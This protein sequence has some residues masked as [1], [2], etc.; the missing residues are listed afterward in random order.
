M[1]STELRRYLEAGD[2]S[3][4]RHLWQHEFPHLPQPQDDEE[5]LVVLHMARTLSDSMTLKLKAYSHRWLLDHGFPSQLPDE[6]KPLA[7]RIYPKVV[8]AVGLSVNTESELLKPVM[9]EVQKAMEGAVLEA[10]G[11]GKEGDIPHIRK[12]MK[13]ARERAVKALTIK[14]K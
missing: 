2:V 8:T 5:A 13:E 12:R 4:V 10:Y 9:A 6:L 1:Y 14:V 7:E 3:G 11:D